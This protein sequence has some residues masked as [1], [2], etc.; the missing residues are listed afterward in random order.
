MRTEDLIHA[1]AADAAT[2]P[3][4]LA[5]A[6]WIALA[7]SAAAAWI[8]AWA[9]L[10][11]RPPVDPAFAAVR[12][13]L[14]FVLT[15]AFGAAA[16]ALAMRLAKPG[17]AV[18]PARAALLMAFALLAT[19]V[20]VELFV[21]PSDLWSTRLVGRNWLVCLIHVPLLSAIPLGVIL[22]AMRR[23]AP[24]SPTRL[25]AAAGMLAGAVGATLYAS[26]CPD[27][28]PL[29]VAA[30]YTLSVGFVALVGAAIGSRL[31]RW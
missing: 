9:M 15:G 24:G 11:P 30:W 23:G 14:K 27:D 18:G 21:T 1:I 28:S 29:F 13:P 22:L 26:H 19:S 25:G 16:A 10:G 17:A 8:V 12:F 4:R 6:V 5:P 2:P 3:K 31:L 7:V 20:L